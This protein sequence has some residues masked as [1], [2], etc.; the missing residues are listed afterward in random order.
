MD[1]LGRHLIVEFWGCHNLDSLELAEE[2]LTRAAVES[3]AT[4]LS[5]KTH[6]FSPQGISGVAII[7]ESH[8]SIHTWPEYGYAAV[9]IFT[10]G[11]KVEPYRAA[12]VLQ[13]YFRPS[14]SHILEMVRGIQRGRV[15]RIPHSK[16]IGGEKRFKRAAY[17]KT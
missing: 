11:D 9:D 2:A 13:R 3:G 14:S 12:E 15:Q 7:A 5:V 10:C 8:I 6:K 17:E 16:L 1:H 4:L